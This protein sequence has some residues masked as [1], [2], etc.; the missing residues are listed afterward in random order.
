MV[1]TCFVIMPIGTQKINGIEYSASD[2]KEKYNALIKKALEDARPGME[3]IRSDEV[4]MP[5]SVSDDI[6]TKL[7][8]SNFVVADISLPNPNVYYELGIRH[9][10]KSGTILLKDKNINNL[11][12]DISHLRYIEYENSTT[13]LK[14]LTSKLKQYFD[15]FVKNTNNPDNQ[16]LKLAL[17]LKF[18]YPKFLDIEEENRKKELAMINILTPILKNPDMFKIFLD[19]NLNQDD[20]NTKMLEFM[21]NDPEFIGEMIKNLVGGGLLKP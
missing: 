5:G 8:F 12:F 18:K 16:F 13:G 10:I 6:L 15:I 9:A 21:Q 1:E 14:D 7:M 4:S 3:I 20:K 11:V 2:L 17:F 19:D